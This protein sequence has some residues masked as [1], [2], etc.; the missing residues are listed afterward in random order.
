MK[1]IFTTL[2]A[3]LMI[4]AQ[5]L[6]VSVKD[7]C[8]QF[9]GDL[10]IGGDPY[11]NK[12]V[13][14]LPG[15]VDNTV[16]FVLPDF[17][18]GGKGKLGNIVL[19]NIPMDANGQLTLE[20]ASLYLDAISLRAS[21]T[22]LNNFVD[23]YD[24]TVYNSYVTANEAMILLSI[25][26][27]LPE[28]IFVLFGGVPAHANNYVLPN[29]GFEGEWTNNEPA[30]WH[31]FGSATGLMADFVTSNTQQFIQSD[32]VRPGSTG[33]NSALISSNMLFGVKANGNC[34]NGQINAGSMDAT[35]AKGNY[36]FSDPANTGFNTP[37]QGR[38]DSVVFWAKYLPADRNVANTENKARMNTVVTTNNRYQDP[39]L[40]ND[41]VKHADYRIASASID[42]QATADMGWQ[43]LS[44]PFEYTNVALEQA[45]AY[46]LATFS[47]NYTPGGGSSYSTGGLFGKSVLD[48]VFI[49]DVELVYNKALTSFERNSKALEF[50]NKIAKVDEAYCDS[51]AKNAATADGVSAQTFI[52]FDHAHKC[53]FVYVIAD[54]YAQS[55]EYNLYRVNFTDSDTKDIDQTEGFENIRFGETRFEKVLI[56]GQ[57]YIRSNDAWFNAAGVRVR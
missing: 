8:G 55:G 26:A 37:F 16:T 44:A 9:T 35:E 13:Y 34:T 47:T 53:I 52:A 20:N 45:P 29:G 19:P 50:T 10:N 17:T 36:N 56:D 18:Y 33:K 43:R 22:I 54:D 3:G 27:D 51:C 57:L 4:S 12:S 38:P 28:P 40:N 25:E 24:G 31:S 48:T 1:K 46:I 15:V 30:G 23:D 11:P 2:V 42:Y 32:E 5:V 14:L 6:A 41:S 49:D 39:E 7:V 21:I